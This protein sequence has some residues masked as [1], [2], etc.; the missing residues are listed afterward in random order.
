[1]Q[2]AIIDEIA[3]GA[4]NALGLLSLV[5]AY[6]VGQLVF[7]VPVP[8]LI[9]GMLET[10]A[11]HR[12]VGGQIVLVHDPLVATV[13][14]DTEDVVTE[15]LI[16]HTRGTKGVELEGLFREQL[17]LQIQ[18]PQGGHGATERV[19]DDMNLCCLWIF[20]EELCHT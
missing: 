13:G 18:G 9:S 1:M 15:G 3:V 12:E 4:P 8:S 16:A 6:L 17:F 20:G 5:L 7:C 2:T 14:E 10:L 11:L 19:P